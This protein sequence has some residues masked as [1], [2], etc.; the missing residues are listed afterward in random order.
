MAYITSWVVTQKINPLQYPTD[1]HFWTVYSLPS[2]AEQNR[3]CRDNGVLLDVESVLQ[4]DNESVLFSKKWANE[5]DY[6]NYCSLKAVK[7]NEQKAILDFTPV[8][9]HGF[10][11][12]TTAW[13]TYQD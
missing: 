1:D 8:D 2:L 3:I 10:T 6:T 12:A 13:V 9:E 7:R 4:S 11:D 5:Q